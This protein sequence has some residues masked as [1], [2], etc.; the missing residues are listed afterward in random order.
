M[1]TFS[2][3]SSISLHNNYA[4]LSCTMFNLFE[5]HGLNTLHIHYYDFI[6]VTI[7]KLIGVNYSQVNLARNF[8]I[9]TLTKSINNIL[10]FYTCLCFY[11]VGINFPFSIYSLY[12][13]FKSMCLRRACA[14]SIWLSIKPDKQRSD[15]GGRIPRLNE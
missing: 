6:T 10:L 4:V 13:F 12:F 3:Q 1:D 2:L 15:V 8:S 9:N 7:S 11:A 14:D 5:F